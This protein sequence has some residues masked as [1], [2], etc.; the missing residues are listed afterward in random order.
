MGVKQIGGSL[1]QLEWMLNLD[2]QG[3]G[4]RDQKLTIGAINITAHPHPTPRIYAELLLDAYRLKAQVPIRGDAGGILCSAFESDPGDEKSW[5]SGEIAK[6][7]NIDLEQPWFDLVEF[8]EANEEEAKKI[9]IPEH[10]KP[11][12][13]KIEYILVPELHILFFE[14]AHHGNKITPSMALKFFRR[15]FSADSIVAKYGPIETTVV[16]KRE[17][18]D[19][20]LDSNSIRELNLV[21]TRPNNDD[22][23]SA[24]Q[25]LLQELDEQGSREMKV[26]H[27]TQPGKFLKPNGK[28]KTLGKIAAKNGVLSAQVKDDRGVTSPLSTID[29][30]ELQTVFYNPNTETF[31]DAFRKAI[32]IMAILI[33]GTTL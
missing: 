13:T 22:L 23:G 14:V 31:M 11:N 24:E 4:M 12:L 30:P 19:A 15:L 16:P 9:S 20:I 27:K 10:L 6:F 3:A 17:V 33:K 8:D 18:V 29:H 28:L 1:F 26:S 25:K 32:S 21:I 7:L 5:V 2:C